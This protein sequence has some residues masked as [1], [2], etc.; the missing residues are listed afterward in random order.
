MIVCSEFKLN[1]TEMKL[2]LVPKIWS[3]RFRLTCCFDHQVGPI[4]PFYFVKFGYHEFKDFKLSGGKKEMSIPY[5]EIN[6]TP[7]WVAKILQLVKG[8]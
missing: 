1:E 7:S 2:K 5:S 6:S 8:S 4:L 3:S